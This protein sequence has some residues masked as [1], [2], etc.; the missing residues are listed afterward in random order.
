MVRERKRVGH[1]CCAAANSNNRSKN[2]PDF[3]GWGPFR[4]GRFE[5]G[6][7]GKQLCKEEI[8]ILPRKEI[9]S[10]VPRTSC[11][12]ILN[13]VHLLKLGPVHSVFP[14][15]IAIVH[16]ESLWGICL[17]KLGIEEVNTHQLQSKKQCWM[18][19]DISDLN[20]AIDEFEPF[21]LALYFS[22][23]CLLGLIFQN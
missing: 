7:R 2:R 18:W 17:A 1:K 22:K 12:V 6:K 4:E 15:T 23:I 3:H 13:W 14:W 8:P 10:V 21:L 19:N 5:G 20:T 11:Q 9:I 16:E